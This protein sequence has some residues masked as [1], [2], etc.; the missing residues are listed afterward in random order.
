MPRQEERESVT[1]VFQAMVNHYPMYVFS[2]DLWYLT[3]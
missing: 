2:W 3:C 1:M